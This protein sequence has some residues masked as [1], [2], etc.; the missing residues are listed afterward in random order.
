MRNV[1]QTSVVL[2]WPPIDLATST[3][4]SLDIYRNGQRL[5]AV[6]NPKETTST[7]VSSLDLNVEY[8]FQLILRTTAGVFPSNLLKVRTHSMTDTSGIRVCFGNVEDPQLLEHTKATLEELGAKWADKMEIDTT[9]FVCT[10]PAATL[11]GAQVS[12]S[13]IKELGSLYE[14]ALKL[15][16]PIVQPTWILACYSE[17]RYGFCLSLAT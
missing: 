2:E 7:R 12:G 4:R 3:L 16:I 11:D 13:N 1:T 9:H 8:T 14:Q 15:T 10:T 6:P 17:K 5:T